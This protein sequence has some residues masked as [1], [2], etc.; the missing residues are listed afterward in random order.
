[1]D[2]CYTK[3]AKVMKREDDCGSREH[4]VYIYESVIEWGGKI[5]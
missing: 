2:D 3:H 5:D 1:V 4:S